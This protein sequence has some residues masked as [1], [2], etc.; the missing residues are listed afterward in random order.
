MIFGLPLFQI[1]YYFIQSSSN[2]FS[3]L[4]DELSLKSEEYERGPPC[5]LRGALGGKT[6]KIAVLPKFCKIER[7]A[8]PC[9]RS[10]IWLERARRASGASELILGR[11]IPKC[12][13]TGPSLDAPEPPGSPWIPADPPGSLQILPD[14]PL[15]FP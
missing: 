8:P 13:H 1:C 10:L 7:G 2:F 14:P 9:Y 4:D 5:E 15:T 11:L 12:T 3:H 6:G